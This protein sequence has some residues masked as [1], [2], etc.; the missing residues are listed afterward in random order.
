[1]P[2]TTAFEWPGGIHTAF[3]FCDAGELFGR[4]LEE[5]AGEVNEEE[6]IGITF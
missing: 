4:P 5:L 2:F 6:V 1:M 3:A